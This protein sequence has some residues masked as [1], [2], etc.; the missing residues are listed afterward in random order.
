MTDSLNDF[1]FSTFVDLL[2]YRAV[3]QSHK[4]AFTFLQDGETESSRLTYQELDRQARAIAAYLQSLGATGSRALL[5]Y[6][7]GLEF[8]AAFFGCL[9]AGVVA[10]PA[11]PPRRNQ[12]MSRLQAIVA[13]AQA[14]IALTTTSL[15][16]N[17]EVHFAQNSELAQLNWL[18]TE[19]IANNQ[20]KAWQEPEITCGSLAFLQYTSGSTGTPKGVMVSHGNLLHNQQVIQTGFQH[21]DKTIGVSWLPLYHDMGLIGNIL[22]PLYLGIHCILM[23][24]VAF[25]QRPIRWLEAISRYR[26]T[27]SGG[28]NF[29]YD[30]CSRKIT[31]E[32]LS[33]LDLSSWDVAFNGAEPVHSDTIER[34]SEVFAPCGF[35]SS[36]FYP[37]YGM[38]ETTLIVSGGLKV[39]P[40]VFETIQ[41]DALEQKRVVSTYKENYEARTLVGCGQTLLEQQIIIAHP[42]T[43]T[44]CLPNE[45]GEIWVSGPSVAQG[46]WDLPEETQRTFQAYLADT[47][48]GP[49][50]RTGDLGFLKDGELFVT[51]RLKDLIIIRGR[52]HYPQ[53]IELTV[54]RSHPALRQGYGAAFSVDVHGE[55]RLA[56]AFEVERNYL[57]N[58]DVN[59]VVTAIRKAV[60]QQHEIQVYA[61][62]LLKT[63]SVP[64]TSSGK[65][66]RHAC[67]SGF[68]A[69]SLDVVADWIE[70][71]QSEVDLQGLQAEVKSLWQQMQAPEQQTESNENNFR[72]RSHLP[73]LVST[74]ETIQRWLVTQM[75]KQLKIHSDEI[76]IQEPFVRYGLDSAVALGLC[77]DLAQWL[78]CNLEPTIFWDYPSIE[79]LAQ[80]IVKNSSLS[81]ST[82]FVSR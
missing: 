59:E 79:A 28:P 46:Y 26:G 32:Q 1:K 81:P 2:R 75:A 55:E 23:S 39:A 67:R 76:D 7:S 74:E 73:N 64:K 16:G 30:L 78:G 42:E 80:H 66:Q 40:P 37:C 17:I 48:T 8:I 33:S 65:I 47:G 61:I 15:L 58:L 57:R 72:E 29:A 41:R 18:A 34:F 10:V 51:G 31:P 20:A 11:Y 71:P 25:L 35:R 63:G 49:F 19:R 22:Q 45:V 60:T 27:T 3:H 6:P 53:D 62:L 21:T 12:N 52:N 14:S 54:E 69:V 56:I 50:L 77:G 70:N 24:P 82:E 43:L 9:Y 44:C 38:A 13:N 4:L 68:L 5:L 36:A